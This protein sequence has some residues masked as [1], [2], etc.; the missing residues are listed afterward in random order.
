MPSTPRDGSPVEIV[1]LCFAV[2]KWLAKMYRDGLY[3]HEGVKLS[4]GFILT[5]V[6]WATR[7]RIHFDENFWFEAGGYYGDSYGS[8]IPGSDCQLRCNFPIV[9][10]LGANITQDPS[11]AKRALETVDKM[12]QSG[13]G[14]RTLSSDDSNY[15]PNYLAEDSMDPAT[16]K[17]ANYHNGP[18]WVWPL[19][20]HLLAKMNFSQF[21]G[22]EE[23]LGNV[24]ILRF[25]YRFFII[26]RFFRTTNF[27][28]NLMHQF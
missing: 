26:S 10:A 19:G 6:E 5:W 1:G 2:V 16:A 7:I 11:R 3:E 25:N 17:G 24:K 18:S 27:W 9:L 28:G 12:L 4:D 14:L 21:D 22:I 23:L 8:S 15:R 20:Y 13:L